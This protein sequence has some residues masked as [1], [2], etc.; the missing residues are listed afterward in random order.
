MANSV[1][2]LITLDASGDPDQMAA[3]VSRAATILT[4]G[5]TVVMPTDTVYGVAA[6][7]SDADAVAR[8]FA[9]KDRSTSSPLAVLVA[10]ELQ[11]LGLVDVSVDLESVVR[12]LVTTW[13]PGALTLVLPRRKSIAGWDLGGDPATIGVRCPSSP[14]VRA[15]AAMIGPLAV[16]SANRSGQP[17]PTS[18]GQAAEGLAGSVSLVID[19]GACTEPASTVLDLTR[20]PAVLLRVGSIGLAELTLPP[21]WMIRTAAESAGG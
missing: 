2:T 4:G 17:T 15:V 1:G 8:L 16:T 21:G 11:G 3:A 13:W 14:V 9:L 6:L 10:T 5:G 12:K 18:A 7:A 19:A 20:R